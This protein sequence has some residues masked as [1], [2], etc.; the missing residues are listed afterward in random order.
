MVSLKEGGNAGSKLTPVTIQRSKL[1][2][3]IVQL[4]KFDVTKWQLGIFKPDKSSLGE[5]Y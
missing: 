1:A 4:L 2:L 3:V 5:G